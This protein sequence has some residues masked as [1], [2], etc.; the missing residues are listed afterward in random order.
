[1]S[2]PTETKQSAMSV[3][4][5]RKAP[6][7]ARMTSVRS[8][9]VRNKEKLAQ[10]CGS[11]MSADRLIQ[12]A[13]TSI[14]KTPELLNCTPASLFGSIAEAATYGWVPD[15][16]LGQAYLVPFG[17]SQRQTKEV[18]LVPGYR[19]LRDLVARSGE[20][21]T[22][23]EA[24]HEGDEWQF[25]GPFSA[26]THVRG[27]DPSRRYTR[28]IIGAYV[29]GKW[30]SGEIKCFF[31]RVEE[32]LAHRDHYCQS[33]KR[34]AN[35]PAKSSGSPWNPKNIHEFACMAMK[36]VLLDA[37]HRGE[38]PLSVEDRRI[39]ARE[40]SLSAIESATVDGSASSQ[41]MLDGDDLM[42]ESP[43]LEGPTV[44]PTAPGDAGAS[45]S[46]PDSQEPPKLSSEALKRLNN[47]AAD[48]GACN[49]I[50]VC[51]EVRRQYEAL[52]GDVHETA[53][54]MAAVDARCEEIRASRG[55]K[56]KK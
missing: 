48:L 41:A 16:M 18:V 11:L 4:L 43:A 26:P 42:A 15:G 9:L 37:I 32:I 55:S 10:A 47:L 7:E 54:I 22:L 12:I 6:I 5:D 28:P 8:L 23:M 21:V 35:D 29:L 45:N 24:I 51:Q 49:E 39:A 31:W 36:T 2:V 30:R 44:S 52:A 17:N 34:V 56:S 50:R 25:N 20:C 53:A 14:R 38:F 3:L 13:C 1:M 27:P 40:S 19:G 33:W 46:D